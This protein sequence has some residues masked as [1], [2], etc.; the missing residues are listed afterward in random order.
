MHAL[1]AEDWIA[2]RLSEFESVIKGVGIWQ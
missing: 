1:A 2:I